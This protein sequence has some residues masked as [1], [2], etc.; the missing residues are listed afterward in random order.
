MVRICQ[1][2]QGMP[3]AL[4]LAASWIRVMTAAEIADQIVQSYHSLTTD[5]DNLPERHRTMQAVFD[6]SW[7]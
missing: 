7:K 3:L 4:E 2:V 6:S 5:L 1:L